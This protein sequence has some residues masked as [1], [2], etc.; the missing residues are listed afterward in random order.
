MPAIPS[1]TLSIAAIAVIA[2]GIFL[3]IG[4]I[5]ITIYY[6]RCTKQR[7]FDIT[8]HNTAEMR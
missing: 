1:R 2:V 8:G 7:M 4:T 5:D 6:L 3:A